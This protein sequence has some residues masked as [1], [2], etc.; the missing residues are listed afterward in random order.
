MIKVV[1]QK[2]KD[3]E[4][5]SLRAEIRRSRAA[6]KLAQKQAQELRES[7]TVLIA[8]NRYLERIFIALKKELT[9]I[10]DHNWK[11]KE[12]IGNVDNAITNSICKIDI[13]TPQ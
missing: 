6:E 10:K 12:A 3:A 4:I 7:N 8:R 13:A 1:P 2:D 5:L 11:A 9:F